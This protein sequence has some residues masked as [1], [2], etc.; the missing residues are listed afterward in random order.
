M[1]TQ[2]EELPQNRVRL[3]V[4][5]P[6]A[7]LEHA[8]EHAASDLAVSLK[9]PGFRKGKVPM[10][11]LLAR[12]G[13]ERLYTDAIESH[14]GGWFRNAAVSER[15]RP[16]EQPE[17]DYE[18]PAS[19][20]ETFRFTATVAVQ[21][22]PEV[23]D[24]TKLEVPRGEAEIPQELIDQELE[25]LRET[26]ATLAP[27][28]GRPAQE[29]DTLVVDLVREGET[30]RDYVVELGA[31]RLIPEI[32]E[33]LIGMSAGET[34]EIEFGEGEKVEATVK[35]VKEKELPELDDELARATSEFDTLAELRADIESRLREQLDDE[36]ER[37]FRAE[38][39]DR[40]V[41][42]S[43]VDAS[44]PLVEARAT[45]LLRGLAR[46]FERRGISLETYLQI[47]NESPEA[48]QE[49][50]LEEAKLSVARELVLDAV[51]DKVGLEVSDG[52]IEELVRSEAEAGEEDPEELLAQIRQSP[53]FERL[54]EDLR[55]RKALDSVVAE[56]EPI[57]TELARAR[58]KLWTPEQEKAPGD[59]KLWTP[60]SKEPA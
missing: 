4:E 56:V 25:A 50:L 21:P 6:S 54:R 51:A 58:E 36:I 3:E 10:P 29:G 13:K 49:R 43:N 17:Y 16:V 9:I 57:P 12:V 23:A 20:A 27:A 42:A 19:E 35:D 26:A 11:V 31:G 33:G 38:A 55:L 7:D 45:E 1:Q 48:L 14:I 39:V 5:V 47:T 60:T 2:V 30:E 32:E 22:R 41:A 52:E 34:K 44:G 24:W 59:T 40:L 37:A 8:V 28:D 15:I 53:T 18:L 46:S